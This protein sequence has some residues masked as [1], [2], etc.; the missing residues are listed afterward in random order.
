MIQYEED[1]YFTDCI[2]CEFSGGRMQAG[3][4]A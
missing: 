1:I 2:V 3:T 4:D